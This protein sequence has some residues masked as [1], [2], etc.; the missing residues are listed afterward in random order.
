[1]S[2]P[3]A[4]TAPASGSGNQPARTADLTLYTADV[5]PDPDVTVPVRSRLAI[6]VDETGNIMTAAGT[7][8]G[9]GE[10]GA[11]IFSGPGI[12]QGACLEVLTVLPPGTPAPPIAGPLTPE[13]KHWRTPH[14]TRSTI[15]PSLI[16]KIQ[17]LSHG[18]V[19]RLGPAHNHDVVET[20]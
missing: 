5:D 18:P 11:V 7:Y 10:D 17:V 15:P 13:A 9:L 4:R 6:E 1:M 3:S 14:G 16:S 20:T 19:A 2:S 8:Q 12:A